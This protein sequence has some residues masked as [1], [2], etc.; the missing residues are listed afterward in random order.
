MTIPKVEG[1][2]LKFGNKTAADLL[3]KKIYPEDHEVDAGGRSASA[4]IDELYEM[5]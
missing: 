5:L 2:N 4:S 3:L 1:T